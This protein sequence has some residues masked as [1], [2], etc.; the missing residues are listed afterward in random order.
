MNWTWVDGISIYFYK[1][2]NFFIFKF[3]FLTQV[4]VILG[5]QPLI[6]NIGNI[7]FLILT[8]YGINFIYFQIM[9]L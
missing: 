6:T 9:V 4:L 1:I 3:F 5:T 7:I 8:A 2:E